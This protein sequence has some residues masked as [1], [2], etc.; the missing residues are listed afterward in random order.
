MNYKRYPIILVGLILISIVSLYAIYEEVRKQTIHELKTRQVMHA[1][2][3]AKGIEDFFEYHMNILKILSR[4][5]HVIDFDSQGKMI[6]DDHFKIQQSGEIDGITR[7]DA[8]GRIIYTLPYEPNLIGTNISYYEHIREIKE[9]HRPVIS[10]AFSARG[11]RTVAM[12]VPVFKNG[13]YHGSIGYLISFNSLSKR[14]L[15]QIQIGKDGYAWM[16]S[17][18]GI[19]LYC[20]VPGHVGNSVFDN[21]KDFPDIIAMAYEM[22]KGNE[23]TTT[24]NFDRIRGNTVEKVTKHAVYLPVHLGNTFWSIVVAT[25]EDEVMGIMKGFTNRLMLVFL[26]ILAV[27]LGFS[28]LLAKTIGIIKEQKKRELAEKEL[29]ENERKYRS[30]YYEYQ[31]L[32]N[33]IPDTLVLLSPDLKI[34]WANEAAAS[35][36]N[37]NHSDIVGQHCYEFRHNRS[38]PCE[39]CPAQRSFQ[40]GKQ[41]FEEINMPDGRVWELRTIPISYDDG[42]TKGVIELSRNIT[43]RKRAEEERRASEERYQ[44]IVQ[45]APTAIYE[46]DFLQN[47]LIS[48]NDSMADYSGYSRDELLSISPFDILADESRSLFADRLK[49]HLSGEKVPETV[50]FKF[51][52]KNGQEFWALLNIRLIYNDGRATGAHVVAQDISELKNKEEELKESQQ[53]LADIIN[54]LPDATVVVDMDKKIIAWNRAM[55]DMTGVKK[56]DMIGQDSH[57]GTVPFY[58]ERRPYLLDLIDMSDEE[59]Q[60]KYQY[61]RRRGN[62]LYAEVFTPALY[63]GKGAYVWATGAPLLDAHGNHMGAIESIRDIT[64]RKGAEEAL[65]ESQ[66]QLSDIINFLPDATLVI[67]KEGKVIAWNRAIE[68]MTGTEAAEML[69]KDNY[70]Y[71]LPFYGE[72][73]PILID[74]VLKPQEEIEAK[75]VSTE[76]GDILLEG[77]AYMPALRGGEVYLVGKASILRD[78]RG[79]VLGAIES[80][81]DITERRHGEESLI[82]AEE[83]YRGIFENAVMGIF[84]ATIDGR[85]ISANSAFARI[86]GY[87]SPGEVLD[88]VKDMARQLY[89]HPE[90]RTEFVRE[91][92]EHGMIKEQEVQFFRKDGSIASIIINGRAVRDGRGNILYYEGAIQDITDRKLLESQLRQAQKMEAIG[93]LAGGIAHDFNNILSAVLG[94]AEMAQREPEVSDRLLRYHEQ[95][96]KAGRRA[97]DLVKQIL[98]F[99]RQSDEELRPLGISPI[100]KEVL[101]L[102]RAS[103]PSTIKIHHDIQ[104]DPDTV[105]ADPT[106]IHQILLNLCTNAAHAMSEGKGELIVSLSP[107]EINPRDAS[108]INHGLTPGMYLQLSVSDT[109]HGIDPG[110]M[111]RIFDPF[112]TTKKPGEGTG[113]GLSVVHGIVKSYNGAITVESKVGEGTTF[114]IYLPL[115]METEGK[116]EVEAAVRIVGG[117]ECIL[118]VD[119]EDNLVQLGKGML[120]GLGYEVIG[121]T[122][123]TEALELF[124]ARPNRFDLVIT[125]MTMP[126]MTGIELVREIMRIRPGVPVVLCTGFSEAITPEKAKAMGVKEFIMKPIIRRQIAAAIRRAIN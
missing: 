61:V 67:D 27:C 40:S 17:R 88:A 115:L 125:D 117:K 46:V 111:D 81:R 109:G 120:S 91:M 96:Y 110:I 116:P 103:L 25:P 35:Q 31:A 1:R 54:F 69:G 41:E 47:K 85:I 11:F 71:A 114:H 65:K 118:F 33:G 6:M 29:K 38:E 55:E 4:Q 9:T 12:H 80:I 68:E 122:S 52:K 60:S 34:V 20:P 107:V 84:Q 83:K 78:S 119:D 10:D 13:K 63:G 108:N 7:T 24:Y 22:V 123:S 3:A 66:Q 57:A 2:Q 89:V 28:Y 51:R 97:K 112:F 74:L 8:D 93:T 26:I 75:Y 45:F 121:R 76:R 90:R 87:E 101:K 126:N 15:E 104:S 62:T 124:R 32:L 19:E 30:L 70:E 36:F 105:I 44:Q 48:V 100:V 16:V 102:L 99:S 56:E 53:R 92:N 79:S 98:A 42:E 14:Y 64:D 49:K 43:A 82:R 94:Y 37:R 23:G 5:N 18:K 73:R 77:E 106:Q 113:M 21:C 50:T 58:G 86:L 39:S 95:I 59:L 72:R